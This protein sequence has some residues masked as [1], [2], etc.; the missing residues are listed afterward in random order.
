M[1]ASVKR[2][3]R[4]ETVGG[5]GGFAG[6]FRLDL[7]KYPQPVLASSTDGVGT[8]L[9][10][11]QALDRH[12]TIGIDLVAMVVD[13]LVVA[14][15]EPL[16]LTDYIATGKVDPD[17]IAHDRL[18][19]RRGLP[20]GR[21]R[22]DR[23][24]DRG[25][26]RG[27]G[28]RRVRHQR[29]RRRCGQRRRR[30]RPRSGAGGRRADRHG[31]QRPALERVLVG[32]PG[33]ARAGR[34]GPAGRRAGPGRADARRG[35]ADPH[36]HLRAGLPG[37]GGAGRGARLRAHHRRRAGRRTWCACCPTGCARRSTAP[38]GRRS[39]S[40][41]SSARPEDS[42]RR[43][44][45]D[46]QPGRRDG[47]GRRRRAADDAL[48][49]LAQRGVPA[50]RLGRSVRRAAPRRWRWSAITRAGPVPGGR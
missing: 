19:R 24:R 31:L 27:H 37:A 48:A 26:P 9:V 42:P 2:T 28:R 49:L 30:A 22:A 46:L 16:L 7:A 43:S 35:A 25:T 10:I 1:K 15:A 39:R 12:D 34:A 45:A 5:L 6:L 23:R 18:G 21:L 50:W 36:A 33:A 29:H 40:S 4:P 3:D 17:K 11:A 47:G 44:R 14:G 38:P 13:D 32:A 20:A 41:I 8:K